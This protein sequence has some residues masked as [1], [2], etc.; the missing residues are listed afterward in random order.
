MTAGEP[1]LHKGSL[2]RDSLIPEFY[3]YIK[4]I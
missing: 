1:S 4:A 2:A 3:F